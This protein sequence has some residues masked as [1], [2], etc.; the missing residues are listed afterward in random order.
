MFTRRCF[1]AFLLILAAGT[2]SYPV[3]EAAPAS[4]RFIAATVW[5]NR[6]PVPDADLELWRNGRCIRTGRT[7]SRG[8]YRFD[9]LDFGQY[10]V[11]AFKWLGGAIYRGASIGTLSGTH[12]YVFR[13]NL[14]R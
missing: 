12:M 5:N 10:E 1:V 13:V 14:Q 4:R 6:I 8:E 2:A 9:N 3:A 7:N 11:R